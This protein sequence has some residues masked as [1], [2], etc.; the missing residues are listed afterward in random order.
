MGQPRVRA[1]GLAR[2]PVAVSA[3]R[4]QLPDAFDFLPLWFLFCVWGV[5]GRRR[6]GPGS[7]SH[8]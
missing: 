5:G 3:L 2:G 1:E 8:I 6:E 7:P 4:A